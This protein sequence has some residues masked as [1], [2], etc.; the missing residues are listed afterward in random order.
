MAAYK[1]TLI[2][3]LHMRVL[4]RKREMLWIQDLYILFW[5][6]QKGRSNRARQ[7]IKRCPIS[8]RRRNVR[9][10]FREPR[11]RHRNSS[12]LNCRVVGPPNVLNEGFGRDAGDTDESNSDLHLKCED[13]STN[14]LACSFFFCHRHWRRC[15]RQ[16]LS[17][18]YRFWSVCV[19]FG[20]FE[21]WFFAMFIYQRA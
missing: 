16:T 20:L 11:T 4:P 7:M 9:D 1:V 14:N 2:F 6:Q 5:C 19:W 13:F 3:S 21:L 15:V 12:K 8:V 18:F 10:A 17:F